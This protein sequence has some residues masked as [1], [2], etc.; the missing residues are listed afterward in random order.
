MSA[1]T[2]LPIRLRLTLGFAGAMAVLL[3]AIATSLYIGMGAVLLDESDTS[4]RTRAEALV[5]GLPQPNLTGPVRG[6]IEGNEAFAQV[7][8]VGGTVVDTSPGLPRPLFTGAELAAF[9]RPT[10]VERRIDGVENVARM[11]VITEKDRPVPVVVI[12][13]KSLSDRSDALKGLTVFFG[14]VGPLALLLSSVIGW[15][16]AGSA[17]HPVEQMRRQASAISA[18][19][20]DRRLTA[21]ESNDEI[22][23]LAE[24]LN[25]ML[26]RLEESIQ[27]ERRF[28]DDA[29]HELRT[30]LTALKSELDLARSRPRSLEEISAALTSAS[31]ETDRLARLADDLLIL[32]RTREGRVALHRGETSLEDVIG[33]SARLFGARADG[34]G[35]RVTTSA[36]TTPVHVDGDRVRR[37]VDNLID[38]ALR[39]SP[40]GGAVR[41]TADA[42]DGVV[43]IAVEDDGPGFAAGFEQ[44]A[45]KPFSRGSDRAGEG[46]GLGLAIVRA[47]AESHGGT[48]TATNRNEGGARVT[49]TLKI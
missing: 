16:V 21:P 5:A 2:R 17:L 41:V 23:R 8:A 20:L 49:M 27:R 10:Y 29:S 33:A 30:P 19:G 42:T 1:L 11:L 47:I 35:V 18:S 6:L 7:L 34:A 37:A 38:N 32:S 4:L 46:A 36:S 45:F 3:A 48:A 13:G 40:I 22:R 43:T 26:A 39:H 28:L 14:I 9:E 15:I 44:L 25:E 12:V 24:T 31:E